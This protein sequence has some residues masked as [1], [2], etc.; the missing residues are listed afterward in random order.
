MSVWHDG[1]LLMCCCSRTPVQDMQGDHA[2]QQYCREVGE[3]LAYPS[4]GSRKDRGFGLPGCG[5]GV[6][7]PEADRA[8]TS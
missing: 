3:G 5:R 8:H 1:E 7:V 2:L 4:S 6:I